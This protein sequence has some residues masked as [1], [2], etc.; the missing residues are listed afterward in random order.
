MLFDFNALLGAI[1]SQSEE[2][3]ANGPSRAKFFR[4]RDKILE[5]QTTLALRR[6][7]RGKTEVHRNLFESPDLQRE[8]DLVILT[9]EICLFVETKA[10]PP[11]EPFR[12]PEK[13]FTRLRRSFRSDTG[14]QKAY[15]QSL[16]L[17]RMVRKGQM[18][19]YDRT[20]SKVLQLP[21]TVSDRAFCV[22]VTNDSFGP[23]ATF[24]SLLLRKKAD[25]PYPWVVSILDLQQIAEMWEGFRWD[26]RQLKS[27]LSQRIYCTARFSRTTSWTMLAHT[28]N[29]AGCIISRRAMATWCSW[30]QRTQP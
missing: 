8:H 25:D 20:G 23:I 15:E 3:L 13:A 7:L 1:L 22:C 30:T 2:F 17:Y 28:S 24:L 9:D 21:R 11:A 26:G 10:T 6:I 18:T 16:S 29:T 19:L 4:S 27:Y 12:D 14:I 5:E